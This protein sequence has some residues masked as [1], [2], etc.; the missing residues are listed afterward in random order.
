[1]SQPEHLIIEPTICQHSP[2]SFTTISNPH[3]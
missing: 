1:M 3:G 2:A